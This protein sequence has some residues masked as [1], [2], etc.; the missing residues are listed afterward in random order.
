MGK[1]FLAKI[2]CIVFS[3]STLTAC[4]LN[5]AMQSYEKGDYLSSIRIVTNKLNEKQEYPRNSLKK[6]WLESVHLSLNR[7]ENLPNL[8]IDQKIKRFETIY[9]ARS[10]LD[11][12]FYRDEFTA[13]NQRYPMPSLKLDIA[14][15]YYQKGNAIQLNTTESYKQK[16]DAYQ[17]GASYAEYL[18]MSKL[19]TRYQFEYATRLAGDYY[20]SGLLQVRI[21]DY[22]AASED[23]AKASEAY[24]AHGNYKDA[25]QQFSKYDQLW[26]TEKASELFLQASQKERSA[27]YKVDFRDIAK[28][29]Q[30]ANSIYKPYG[31]YKNAADLAGTAT[32][33]GLVRVAYFIEQEKG[34]DRCGKYSSERLSERFAQELNTA[35]KAAPFRLMDRRSDADIVVYFDYSSD[36]SE[37]RPEKNNQVQSVVD[38]ERQVFKFNQRTEFQ[39]NKY[40]MRL[41]IETKGAVSLRKAISLENETEQS[42]VFYSGDVPAGYR[43]T[44]TGTLKNQ[45][46]LCQGLTEDLQR[47]VNRVLNDIVSQAK[48]I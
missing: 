38:H 43:N 46:E 10:L 40:E 35:F 14:K 42:K 33:K 19:A 9:Q 28:L 25:A 20:Q 47:Q 4:T 22:Q 36:Y 17:T 15:L 12:G 18:D 34:D 8:S 41:I 44:T 23:F 6:S 2:C 45:D 30:D 26:R 48:R 29:Y 39:K 24:A 11:A 7:I 13:F 31:N 37:G 21:K 1:T 32:Q 16:A 3:V 27:R 5:K